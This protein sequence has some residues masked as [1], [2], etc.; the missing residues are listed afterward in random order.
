MPWRWRSATCGA[1]DALRDVPESSGASFEHGGPLAV[2][3]MRRLG[4]DGAL[5][6]VVEGAK[7]EPLA[8]GSRTRAVPPA[9]KPHGGCFRGNT[10]AKSGNTCAKPG[11]TS[12][13]DGAQRLAEFN[14]SRGL[15]IEAHTARCGWGGERMDYNIAID[16]LCLE[17]GYN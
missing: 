11:S 7:G 1:H 3:T 12:A 2:E 10:C 17:A 15:N 13:A 5:I 9:G 16:G 6:G 4:C 8:I 14:A